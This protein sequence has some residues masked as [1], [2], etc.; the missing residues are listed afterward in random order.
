[1]N[2]RRRIQPYVQAPLTHHVVMDVLAEY[3]RPNDKIS[4]LVR[5]GE[6]ISLR[7][8]LYI[9]GPEVDLPTPEPFLISNH[10]RGPSYISLESA[11]AYWEM[12]PERVFEI[13]AI[14][15]KT[16]KIYDTPIGR[17]TYHHIKAPYYTFGLQRIE[18]ASQQMAII[19]SREKALCDLI[20]LSSG[21]LLRSKSQ[22]KSYLLED[23]RLDVQA[24]QLLSI[25][26]IH[27]WLSDVPKRSSLQMLIHTL[28]AL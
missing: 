15:L 28:E 2:F 9:P 4:E 11:L 5:N 8:G 23:L 14:T 12:I 24:L 21:V 27:S 20:V 18:V 16:S 3:N 19:A 25:P 26:T 6:L 22:T 13:S 7:R 17:F 10:M 1:M